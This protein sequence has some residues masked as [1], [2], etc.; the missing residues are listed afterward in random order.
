MLLCATKFAT[1]DG[2]LCHMEQTCA[3]ATKCAVYITAEDDT[4]KT[5]WDCNLFQ[6]RL[7]ETHVCHH[8][9]WNIKSNN[10]FY[11]VTCSFITTLRSVIKSQH[12][13]FLKLDS[14]L[15]QRANFNF[16]W[17]FFSVWWKKIIF[18]KTNI[19]M[20]CNSIYDNQLPTVFSLLQWTWHQKFRYL[21]RS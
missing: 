5:L 2:P 21:N 11:S 10:F 3:G 14:A 17:L 1:M 16:F 12:S 13:S 4:E 9:R 20:S 8:A 7:F 15:G 19:G 18:G 6:E